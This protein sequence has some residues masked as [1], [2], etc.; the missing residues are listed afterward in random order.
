MKKFMFFKRSAVV[1]ISSVIIFP[2]IVLAS[3]VHGDKELQNYKNSTPII[4]QLNST[5]IYDE[6]LEISSADVDEEERYVTRGA[7]I[8]MLY[9]LEGSPDADTENFNF[10]DVD[11]NS[12]CGEA[13]CWAN[14]KGIASG[15]NDKLFGTDDNI[16]KEQ[17]FCMLYRYTLFKGIDAPIEGNAIHEF[18]D[19]NS[20]SDY[21]VN[22]IRWAIGTGLIKM[23][24]SEGCI[25][26]KDYVIHT[27]AVNIIEK[28]C[29]LFS[30]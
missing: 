21:A 15:Y 25:N 2:Q 5:S 12:N 23:E 16:T 11:I 8:L 10:D 29:N 30:N 7:F 18:N 9:K 1:F 24:E 17:L 3:D 19:E 6:N 26:P 13:I 20:V 27:E 22:S 28:Y 4:Y 14:E